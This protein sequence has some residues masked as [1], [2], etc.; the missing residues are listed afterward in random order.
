MVYLACDP[1]LDHETGVY[2]HMRTRKTIDER[3]S[4][5]AFGDA[6]T[7]KAL[8]IFSEHGAL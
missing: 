8:E 5:P 3:A 6:F 4:D 1:S 7:K 2:L